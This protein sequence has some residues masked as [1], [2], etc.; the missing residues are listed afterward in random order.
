[1]HSPD[2]ASIPI[3]GGCYCGAVRYEVHGKLFGGRSCHCSRC[4]KAYSGAG[5]THARVN[6]GEFRWT[7]GEESVRYFPSARDGHGFCGSCGSTLCGVQNGVVDVIT[8]GTV[9]GDP[10]VSID[11]HF[12]VGSK[13]VWDE[14]GGNAPRFEE[15]PS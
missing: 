7:A 6:P 10:G 11:V 15:W 9:D 3:R 8:L 4:R 13:A 2:G 1:M 12:F 14:I 5:S